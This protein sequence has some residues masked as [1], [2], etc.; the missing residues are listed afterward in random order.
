MKKFLIILSLLIIFVIALGFLYMKNT[1]P[2]YSGTI[3]DSGITDSTQVIYDDFGIPHIYAK[4]GKDAYFALGYAHAQERLFQMVMLRRL[5]RGK[6]AEVLGPKLIPIDKKMVT[7]GFNEFAKRNAEAVI[8]SGN[9]QMMTYANAYQQGVNSFIDNGVLPI[10]F[11][12]LGFKPEHFIVEDIYTTLGFMALGFTTGITS[13]PV[14]QYIQEKL[15]NDFVEIFEADSLAASED[16]H[17]N[18]VKEIIAKNI[19]SNF[20]AFPYD[21]PM[22]YWEG[23]NSWLLSKERSKS[24]KAIFAN[25]T[26]IGYSQPSVWYEA[27]MEYPGFELYGYYLAGMPFAIIGH[28]RNL[29]WGITIFPMDNMDLYYETTKTD[30]RKQYLQ[31]GQWKEYKIAQ[32]TIK[33]KD[34]TD[35]LYN[36][37]YSERGPVLNDAFGQTI[38]NTDKDV[39]LWWTL[40]HKPTEVLEATF[41]MNKAK[42]IDEFAAAMPKIDILG[43]NIMYADVQDNIAWWATGSLPKR[44]FT[45][46]SKRYMDGATDTL[47]HEFYSFDHNP[48]SIN[49]ERGYI[50]T[51]NNSPGMFD[52]VVVPGYYSPGYRAQRIEKLLTSQD[53]WNTEELKK[54]QT[55]VFSERDLRLV[56]IIMDQVEPSL[57]ETEQAKA[58]RAWD[59]NYDIESIGATIFTKVLYKILSGVF[60]D[61]LGEKRFSELRHTYS[62]KANIERLISDENSVWFAGQRTQI[63]NMAYKEALESLQS[64]LGDDVQ[65]WKWGRVHQLEHVHAI[66]R[67]K[68]FDKVFNVGPFPKSGSNE[69]VDKEGFTYTDAPSLKIKSG[70]ALRFFVDFAEPTNGIGIIPT[71]Q[72]GNIMSPHYSDQALMFVNGEYRDH[73]M[74]KQELPSNRVLWFVRGE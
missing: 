32:H 2:Q 14:M 3:A 27:Y 72:S 25:D 18:S 10:E 9:P 63:I 60:E 16:F 74:V 33:V 48:K 6:L 34:S 43:L 51:A 49:P 67:K 36:V 46:N 58:L 29:A 23:S 69:V 4:S 59:G 53:K 30:D 1:A 28:N 39:S 45:Q 50:I 64:Q 62:L 54:V 70:P 68:P 24:G 26:H 5:S 52:S 35:V 65:T 40:H 13:E 8:K 61:K 42:N 15:G 7:L 21:M 17:P 22:P 38:Q 47:Q 66:G 11:V 37:K 19:I 73:I 12:M 56:N 41:E 20:D 57:L 31:N 71:G 44:A 55:D